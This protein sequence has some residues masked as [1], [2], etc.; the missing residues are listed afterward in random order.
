MKS[1]IIYVRVSTTGQ[2]DRGTEKSQIEGCQR[3]AKELGYEV[4]PEWL[5]RETWTGADFERPLLSEARQLIREKRAD[6]LIVYSTDRLARNPLHVG[7][8][9]EECDKAA[10]QLVIVT[11]PD[12]SSPEGQLIRYVRGWGGQ[13]E[14]LKIS[15]RTQR[16]KR[17]LARHGQI[18]SGGK[19]PY[20]YNVVHTTVDG[21]KK[22][23][24]V[25]NPKEA[26]IIKRMFELIG[27][28]GYTIYRVALEFNQQEIPAPR[29]QKWSESIIRTYLSNTA[30]CGEL[31]LFKYKAIEPKKPQAGMRRIKKS[32]QV[33]R[34]KS[35]WILIP[36]GA[37]P[38]ISRELYDKAHKQLEINSRK[39]SRNRIHNQY[40][41]SGGI[42]RCGI[43][44]HAMTSGYQ[45]RRA[46]GQEY[47]IY[48]CASNCHSPIYH[49]CTMSVINADDVENAV[50]N[51]LAQSLKKR[52]IIKQGISNFR[53]T[54]NLSKIETEIVLKQKQLDGFK[55]ERVV[56]LRQLGKGLIDETTWVKEARRCDTRIDSLQHDIDDMRRRIE[57]L[58]QQALH[59]D[60]LENTLDDLAY[61]VEHAETFEQKRRALVM[62]NLNA[63]LTQDHVV[64]L[65]GIVPDKVQQTGALL[66]I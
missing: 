18:T 21:R 38:I 34:D 30:Y 5:F 9:A 17:F 41:F 10:C 53:E 11:E 57:T 59:Y 20:G 39:A 52:E 2:A 54:N 31:Y 45:I 42:L 48:R 35:E 56:Y 25:I 12:D 37:P 60:H 40:L 36:N 55:Q 63:V 15:E 24:W 26:E 7:L 6:A 66:L 62:I 47:R 46:T 58:K 13:F 27:N 43:C 61:T 3:K 49:R 23:S 65:N 50:W 14:R 32:S 64:K 33:L 44:G 22:I 4:P 29:S 51:E 16:G 1:A 8:I 19:A 28:H